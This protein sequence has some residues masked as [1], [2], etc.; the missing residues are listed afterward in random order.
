MVLSIYN[1]IYNHLYILPWLCHT[2]GPPSIILSTIIYIYYHGYAI[3][4]GRNHGR[5]VMVI[6][7]HLTFDLSMRC[8]PL[9]KVSCF[10]LSYTKGVT[11]TSKSKDR[12]YNDQ[13]KQDKGT[14][15]DLKKHT[16]KTKNRVT[17]TPLKPE[18]NSSVTIKRTNTI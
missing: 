17:Q 10:I 12:Q 5:D 7:L 13:K 18:V 16:R 8:P 2:W 6:W 1:T 4:E 3:P 14:N 15:N 9:L 11:R